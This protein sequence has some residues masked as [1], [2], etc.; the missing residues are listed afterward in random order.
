[1]QFTRKLHAIHDVASHSLRITAC[2]LDNI[3]RPSKLVSST[4]GV[5]AFEMHTRERPTIL[6]WVA[7]ATRI[8]TDYPDPP[9]HERYPE[10]LA[11]LA[12]QA[13]IS[14]MGITDVP[15]VIVEVK[16][17]PPADGSIAG[18][19]FPFVVRDGNWQL[20]ASLAGLPCERPVTR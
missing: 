1:M 20:D 17:D 4:D 12:R 8:V 19:L 14:A 5:V 3:Q 16:F 6:G 2:A 11:S 7:I 10:A 9:L 13:A 15:L 18:W